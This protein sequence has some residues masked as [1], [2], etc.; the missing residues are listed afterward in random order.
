MTDVFEQAK[1]RARDADILDIARRH[2]V[3]SGLKKVGDE[4]VGPCPRCGGK[5]RFA[6][7]A[8]K[9]GGNGKPGLFLCRQCTDGG[10]VIDLEQFLSGTR[11]KDALK[12]LGGAPIVEENPAEAARRARWWAFCRE[13]IEET[14]FGLQPVL[15]SP[16][17]VFFRDE[18]CIDTSLPAIRRPL[19]TV[20]AIGWHPSVY[21]SQKDPDEPSHELHG[22]RL[23][24]IVGIM[25]DPE[26]GERRG[27]ISRTYLS[28]GEKVGKAK[29]LKRAE[30]EQS[31]GSR[32]TRTSDSSASRQD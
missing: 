6:I 31:S 3:L 32:R 7:N 25:T 1:R 16:G 11:F 12:D 20:A 26:T 19:G 5:D 4:Y 23:G 18:R 17:E 13:V 10:D 29:T 2:G 14:I 15:G 21:Y 24:C 22:Q 27:P 30:A 8:R 9:L 28:R